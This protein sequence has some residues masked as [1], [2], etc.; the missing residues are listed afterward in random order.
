MKINRPRLKSLA[1]RRR[2]AKVGTEFL[3]V[4]HDEHFRD[5]EI[6]PGDVADYFSLLRYEPSDGGGAV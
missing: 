3:P 5:E 6:S 1:V 2:E 4:A